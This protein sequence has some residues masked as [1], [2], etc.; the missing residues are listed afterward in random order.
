MTKTN[1]LIFCA[2]LVPACAGGDS[3]DDETTAGSIAETSTS[4]DAMTTT[5][6]TDMTTTM[7]TTTATTASTLT[8]DSPESSGS[9]DTASTGEPAELSCESY[10][11]IYLTECVD[12]SEYSNEA[13][14]LSNCAAWPVGEQSDTAVDSLG[15]RIYHA[16]VAGSTDPDVHCP[17]AGPSGAATCVQAAAPDCDSYCTLFATNCVDGLYTYDDNDDCLTQC[18]TWYP[19]TAKDTAGHTIGCHAYHAG[20]AEADPDLHCPHSG[21]GGGGICVL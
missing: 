5:M 2:F 6:T 8:T 17:H 13:D 9:E 1:L 15:C 19:G 18:A 12:F 14:C 10:C 21:A 7:T 11:S 3:D 4:S 16:T 20:A